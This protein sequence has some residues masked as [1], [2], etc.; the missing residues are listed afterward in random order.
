MLGHAATARFGDRFTLIHCVLFGAG[1][2]YFLVRLLY[3]AIA[4]P[5]HQ[6]MTP[7]A[8]IETHPHLVGFPVLLKLLRLDDATAYIAYPVLLALSL[9]ALWAYLTLRYRVP[10]LIATCLCLSALKLPIISH[11]TLTPNTDLLAT[12]FVMVVFFVVAIRPRARGWHFVLFMAAMLCHQRSLVLAPGLVMF[13]VM[14]CR[15]EQP[16][17]FRIPM[18]DYVIAA[19]PYIAAAIGFFLFKEIYFQL[20]PATGVAR[21]ITFT[22]QFNRIFRPENAIDKMQGGPFTFVFSFENIVQNGLFYFTFV[23]ACAG[24]L[25]LR[26][27]SAASVPLLLHLGTVS[28]LVVAEDVHRL[29]GFIFVIATLLAI[30]AGRRDWPWPRITVAFF[31]LGA[32]TVYARNFGKAFTL[33]TGATG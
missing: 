7:N 33:I 27:Y 29:T 14:L 3:A 25:K 31:A 21:E 20:F 18:R 15:P 6:G 5:L 24:A 30:W 13:G 22:E 2:Y 19:V 1:L 28:Q 11:V 8:G 4:L 23:V 9:L 16:N 17:P 32:I 26:N 12:W 10:L